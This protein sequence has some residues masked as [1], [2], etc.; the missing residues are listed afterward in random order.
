MRLILKNHG[1]FNQ[2]VMIFLDV[3]YSQ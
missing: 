2:E 3:K 1:E